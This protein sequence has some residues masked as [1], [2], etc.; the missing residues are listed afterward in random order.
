M[1]NH[2]RQLVQAVSGAVGYAALCVLSVAGLP[3]VA[4]AQTVTQCRVTLAWDPNPIEENVASYKLSWGTTVSGAYSQSVTV[5]KEVLRQD[6]TLPSGKTYFFVV[7]AT[8]SSGNTSGYSNEV[9]YVMPSTCSGGTTPTRVPQPL[10][11]PA[12]VSI[13]QG[14]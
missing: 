1:S 14:T 7:Q 12:I 6:L 9:R 3:S 2:C 5:W 13:I 8:D 10:T 11:G 4:S